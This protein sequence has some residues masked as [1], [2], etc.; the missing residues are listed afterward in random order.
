MT[1]IN[2]N[3]NIQSSGF[4]IRDLHYLIFHQFLLCKLRENINLIKKKNSE[5]FLKPRYYY[6]IC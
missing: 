5:I 1:S 3:K 2:L 6:Y 4:A